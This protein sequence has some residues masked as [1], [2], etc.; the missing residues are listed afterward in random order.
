M[1]TRPSEEHRDPDQALDDEESLGQHQRRA[2]AAAG[3]LL[4]QVQA[5][6]PD[7]DEPG[8]D[9]PGPEQPAVN[10]GQGAQDAIIGPYT[11]SECNVKG[12]V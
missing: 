7:D 11:C 5:G 12:N 3:C 1:G 9:Q 4:A 8:D 6:A 2:V 10:V